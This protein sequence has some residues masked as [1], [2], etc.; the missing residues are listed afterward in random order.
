M[1]LWVLGLPGWASLRPAN[2]KALQ[3]M[4]DDLQSHWGHAEGQARSLRSQSARPVQTRDCDAWSV[5]P[6]QPW[7]RRG[8]EG[9]LGV[10][11]GSRWRGEAR[12]TTHTC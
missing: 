7:R 9:D 11:S 1:S 8:W 3:T 4:V 10:R 2:Q 5:P 6:Q 12:L